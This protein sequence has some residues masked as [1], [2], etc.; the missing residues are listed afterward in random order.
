[1]SPILCQNWVF[2]TCLFSFCT[3]LYHTQKQFYSS[4][5]HLYLS[6]SLFFGQLQLLMTQFWYNDSRTCLWIPQ[7]SMGRHWG[8]G[9]GCSQYA[10]IYFVSWLILCAPVFSEIQILANAQRIRKQT[11]VYAPPPPTTGSFR[12]GS[13]CQNCWV[14][15]KWFKPFPMSSSKQ[16]HW[17]LI[18]KSSA[19]TNCASFC[20]TLWSLVGR[21]AF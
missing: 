2:A 8:H 12:E 9:E 16:F 17:E 1:M 3:W 11:D 21:T 13:K 14:F 5:L 20:I 10:F 19:G 15:L 4:I 6:A 7:M 18:D